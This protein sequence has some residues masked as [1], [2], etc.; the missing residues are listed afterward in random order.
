MK[1]ITAGILILGAAF[2]S[3]WLGRSTARTEQV[4][5]RERTDTVRIVTPE[6]MVIKDRGPV[7]ARLHVADTAANTKQDSATVEI[8]M[9]QAVYT[10][11]DYTAYVSGFRPSLDSLVMTRHIREYTLPRSAGTKR[12]NVGIQA[13]YGVTPRGFQPYIGIG[14]SF[15]IF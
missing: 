9:Q 3:F 1:N 7:R 2:G 10:G 13:G 4:V 12:W 8:P 14:I 11:P 6:V 15:S 5:Y